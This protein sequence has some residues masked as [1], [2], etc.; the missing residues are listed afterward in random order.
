MVH[1]RTELSE[2][3]QSRR[4]RLRPEDVGLHAEAAGTR[5]VPGLRR[6]EL[7]QLAGVSVDYYVRLEQGRQVNASDQVL[8]ALARALGLNET[9]RAHLVD[10]ARPAPAPAASVIPKQRARKG[11]RLLL[12]GLADPAFLLGPRLEVLATNRMARTLLCDFDA[13]PLRERNHARWLFLEP[14]NRELYLDWERVARS[15]VAVLR[16]AAG[17]HPDDAELAALVGELSVK[18]PGFARWWAAHEVTQLNHGTKRY[19]H[20]VVG[21]LTVSYEALALPDDP[22]QTLFVYSAEPGSA[23]EAALRLLDNWAGAPGT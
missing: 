3:L 4:A 12:D 23:S 18:S 16:L 19:R 5:R 14:A 2:F 9:E 20:P 7:A 6:E 11:I 15:N 8:H 22:D 17:R 13:L 10:V 21:Q 1:K